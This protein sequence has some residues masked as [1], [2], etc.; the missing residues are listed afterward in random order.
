MAGIYGVLLKENCSEK[1][2]KNFYNSDFENLLQEELK[3]KHHIFGRSVLNKFN[4]DRFLYENDSYIVCLEGINYSKINTPQK[5]I[6]AYKE[7]GSDFVKNLEGTFSGFIFSKNDEEL[8]LFTDGLSTKNIY[9]Y[10]DK[11]I[12][13]AFSSEMHVLSKLLRDH[14]IPISYDYDGIYS[15]ALYGQ[16]FNNFTL[17]KEIKK[18]NY[19]TL[20]TFE[21]RGSAMKTQQYYKISKNERSQ[22]KEEVVETI[23]TL[24]TKSIRQEWQKDRD[25]SYQEHLCLLSGG[26]DSRVNTIVAKELGFNKINAFT[27]GNPNSSDVKF[28]KEIAQDNFYSHIQF[29]LQKGDFLIEIILNNYVKA[30]DGLTHFTANAIIYNALSRIEKQNYGLL[31]SGQIGD[32]LF[33]SFL[34]PNYD[35]KNN[36]DKIGLTGFV[37]NK[38]MLEKMDFL[39]E[40]TSKYNH[41]D[42]E[43]FG[44]EQRQI[45]GTL[46]GDNVFNNF[47]DQV[48]PFYNTELLDY[49]LTIPNNFKINQKIYFDWLKVKHPK[50]LNYKWEKIGLKPNSDFNINYG[51]LIKKYINGGKKYFGLRYDSM[52]PITNWFQANPKLLEKFN[53]IFNEN[54]DLIQDEELKKDLASIYKND[55]FEYRNRFAVI[56]VLLAIKLH[57]KI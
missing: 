22:S 42:Y 32:V 13:F 11:N 7:Q 1:L 29:N 33:G 15:L 45:N 50:T 54:I 5:I 38:A 47:I 2:Y 19:G 10:Y 14:E 53:Q 27:Y 12:G 36:K 34:R 9:Y 41:S 20:L 40:L 30:T 24:M 4:D 6:D 21:C 56:T 28:A 43:V 57:F 37:K 17:V 18:I 25:N 55:I 35:F 26:M 39:D 46:M 51:R 48:S 49:C 23:E 16:M 3:S 44:F 52:N 8:T 31:H